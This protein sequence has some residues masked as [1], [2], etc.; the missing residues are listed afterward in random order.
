MAQQTIFRPSPD[1]T[2]GSGPARDE[3]ALQDLPARITRAASAQAFYTARLLVDRDRV[4]D[5]YRAYAYFRW[6]DDWLDQRDSERSARLAFVARQ[7]EV[8][9]L[10]YR[11]DWP[12][13]LTAE[14]RMLRELIQSDGEAESGLGSYIRNMMA[15][16]AFDAERRGRLI[17]ERELADYALRLATA[18]TDALHY[19]IGHDQPPPPSG[20]RYLPAMAAHITH[21]LRDTFEDID[22]GYFNVPREMLTA[23]GIG[24]RDVASAPYRAWVRDRVRLARAYFTA[25]ADYLDRVPSLRCRLAGYAYIAR[26]TGILD[27]IEREG[28]LL[29]SAYPEVKAPGYS[30]RMAGS[31]G[32]SALLRGGR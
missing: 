14:E 27:A 4:Q 2:R 20:A 17:A 5:A 28:Y 3:R 18:V 24:P 9:E 13:D 29:R 12:A 15:V 1:M 6:V 16:M 26:F 7:R 22:A 31:V 11:G 10:G 23:S 19:F 30:L 8:V 25:G 32:A 21:M